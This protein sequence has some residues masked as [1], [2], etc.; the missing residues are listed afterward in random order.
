M[1][2]NETI[3]NK[4]LKFNGLKFYYN[5][6]FFFLLLCSHNWFL[7]LFN[8]V[9]FPFLVSFQLV[10]IGFILFRSVSFLFK[11]VTNFTGTLYILYSFTCFKKLINDS[12]TKFCSP[13]HTIHP[14]C[15]RGH[16]CGATPGEDQTIPV[17]TDGLKC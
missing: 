11:F 13:A 4:L 8:F 14:S 16:A 2:R 17:H 10:S 5:K 9:S 12:F 7:I 3:W 1:K 15:W 6:W